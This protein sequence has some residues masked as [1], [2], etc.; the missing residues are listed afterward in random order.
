MKMRGCEFAG[1]S[2]TLG[3]VQGPRDVFLKCDFWFAMKLQAPAEHPW[4]LSKAPFIANTSLLIV[5]EV[6]QDAKKGRQAPA[7]TDT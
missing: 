3:P 2:R 1:A 5:A 4:V 7:G 6:A